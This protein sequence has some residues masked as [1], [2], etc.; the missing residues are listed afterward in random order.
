MKSEQIVEFVH[1]LLPSTSENNT[2]D[3]DYRM[4]FEAGVRWCQYV[5]V[6]AIKSNRLCVTDDVRSI[7]R[8]DLVA[9]KYDRVIEGVGSIEN[10]KIEK[11]CLE[12]EAQL[13]Q[14]ND[15]LIWYSSR[16]ERFNLLV[17][18]F[19]IDIDKVRGIVS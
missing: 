9:P 11:R 17:D 4:G 7:P 8:E 12:L 16:F 1:K 15:G 14:A 13:K 2:V 10:K 19:R 18:K 5:V 6:D 3:A